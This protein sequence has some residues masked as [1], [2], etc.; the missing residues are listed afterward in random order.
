M[1]DMKTETL[2]FRVPKEFKTSFEETFNN[3]GESS[4]AELLKKMIENYTTVEKTEP[5][6]KPEP[7]TEQTTE[8]T[9]ESE[10]H[11][12]QELSKDICISLNPVQLF[13]MRET[14]LKPEFIEKVNKEVDNI[15]NSRDTS[16]FGNSL[17]SGLYAGVFNKMNPDSENE[18][19]ISENIA[20]MLVNLFMSTIISGPGDHIESP[21]TNKMLKHFILENSTIGEDK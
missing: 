14:V 12:E 2:S 21:V 18:E 5:G 13:A 7:E 3:S 8:T 4:K 1:P 9:L 16:F 6:Q 11:S 15:D 19:A 10:Q 17:F 20:A